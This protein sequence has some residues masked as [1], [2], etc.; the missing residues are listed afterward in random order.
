MRRQLAATS[1]VAVVADIGADDSPLPEED[2]LPIV[3]LAGEEDTSCGQ[4]KQL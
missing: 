4:C 1:T 2:G 3:G